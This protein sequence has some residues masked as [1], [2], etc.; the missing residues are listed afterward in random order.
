MSTGFLLNNRLEMMPLCGE[1]PRKM[2]F[3]PLCS[4]LLSFLLTLT[5]S[6]LLI[7]ARSECPIVRTE[8]TD[9]NHFKQ[10]Y[11]TTY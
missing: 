3:I 6:S 5:C 9:R 8:I 11:A 10:L 4:L 7:K 2:V 1:D